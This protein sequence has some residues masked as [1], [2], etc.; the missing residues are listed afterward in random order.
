MGLW[1]LTNYANRQRE[2]NKTEK[3]KMAQ[4]AVDI[5]KKYLENG[6]EYLG[7][8]GKYNLLNR[9]GPKKCPAQ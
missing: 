7:Q 3:R 6:F 8:E 4:V 5:V 1:I 2:K 9:Y